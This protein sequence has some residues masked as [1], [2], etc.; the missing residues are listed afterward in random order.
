MCCPE[1][2]DETRR[3]PTRRQ[4]IK[5]ARPPRDWG[6]DEPDA[7]WEAL[8]DKGLVTPPAHGAEVGRQVAEL[9]RSWQPI[10]KPMTDDELM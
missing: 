7:V 3:Q 10:E 9:V 8:E 5:L 2:A 4:P 1:H 6:G